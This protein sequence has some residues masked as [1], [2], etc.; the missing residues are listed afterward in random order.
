MVYLNGYGFPL[1]RGGPMLY[2]DTVG[3]YHVVR[4]CEQFAQ[5]PHTDRAF[6]QPARLLARLAAEG[7]SFAA[8]D[9]APKPKAKSRARARAAA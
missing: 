8:F 3:L 9:A 1:H 6:W 2:A 7:E 5:D 4:R